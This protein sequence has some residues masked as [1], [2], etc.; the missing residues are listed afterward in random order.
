MIAIQT[1]V[2]ILTSDTD[3]ISDRSEERKTGVELLSQAS[4]VGEFLQALPERIFGI[5][6]SRGCKDKSRGIQRSAAEYRQNGW[7][8]MV[9][10]EIQDDYRT[11]GSLEPTDEITVPLTQ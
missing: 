7:N 1:D 9:H 3:K 10:C 6:I 5:Q 4:S 11:S 2:I 8:A